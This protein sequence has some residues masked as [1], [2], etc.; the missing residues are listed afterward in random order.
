MDTLIVVPARIA[1]TR[2]PNKIIADIGGKPLIVHTWESVMSAKVGDVIVACDSKEIAEKIEKAGGTAIITDPNIPSGSDRVFSAYKI[3]GKPYKFIINVQ[4]D[5]PFVESQIIQ[6]TAYLIKYRKFDITTIASEVKDDT[7]SHTQVVK[8]VIAFENTQDKN[9]QIG[10]ALY[11]SRS[12]VPFGGPYYKHIG[13]YGFRVESLEKF[14]SL[15]QGNLEK[16][17]KLEQLRALE[18]NMTI[19][20]KILDLDS[21]IS[22]D[23]F[24]D[25]QNAREYYSMNNIFQK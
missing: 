19:G 14:V 18:N 8:P 1:S 17:E 22:V 21:P 13:I 12:P 16:I 9:N 5:M 2:L 4:G 15:P 24:D 10:R 25:L 23:T 7:Y 11:F 20:I 3:F 6:E